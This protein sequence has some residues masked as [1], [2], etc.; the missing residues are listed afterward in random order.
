MTCPANRW[1]YYQYSYEFPVI[2]RDSFTK[3]PVVTQTKGPKQQCISHKMPPTVLRVDIKVRLRTK[4]KAQKHKRV[5][6]Q[7]SSE[8]TCEFC[9]FWYILL[10]L[11]NYQYQF[12]IKQDINCLSYIVVYTF[13]WSLFKSLNMC[14]QHRTE[15]KR[16]PTELLRTNFKN[17]NL[18]NS[19]KHIRL[20]SQRRIVRER[21]RP[22]TRWKDQFA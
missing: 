16:I 18:T 14:H 5:E 1:Y 11:T 7:N 6:I 9:T 21:G 12:K 2:T 3:S 13:A 8:V 22:Q 4:V 20:P 17:A 19:S 10:P 15:N